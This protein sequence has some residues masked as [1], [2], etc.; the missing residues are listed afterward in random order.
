MTLKPEIVRD[1]DLVV[2]RETSSGL[3][4]GLPRGISALPGGERAGT[5]TLTNSESKVERIARA[6]FELAR[7]RTG[8][9]TSVDKANVL[10]TMVLWRDVVSQVSREYPDVALSHLHVDAAA[11]EL[12]RDPKQFDVMVTE[13]LFG[14]I[15]SDAA[16]TVHAT[17]PEIA[18]RNVANPIAAILSAAMMLRMSFRLEEEATRIEQAVDRVL[19]SGLRTQDIFTLEGELVGTTQMGD[20]V[21]AALV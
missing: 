1:L 9:L 6:G 12:L 20:A 17:A 5:N 4:F 15:L 19:D 8:K 14:D 2:V 7:R 11:M 13:N 16:A 18:G 10:E 21:V 3:Y